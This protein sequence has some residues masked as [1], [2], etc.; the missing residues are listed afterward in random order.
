MSSRVAQPP[1]RV[2][3]AGRVPY[4]MLITATVMLL[5]LGSPGTSGAQAVRGTL[6]GKVGDAQGAAVP[7][8]TVTA[9][10]TQTNVARHVVTNQD[11]NYVFANLKDGLYRVEA[12]LA[13]FKKFAR[14][15]VEVKVNSTV[16]VDVTLEVGGLEETV[17]VRMETP[18][19]QT[20]RADTGRTIEGRQVTDLPLG[21]ARNFQGMW[22][23]VPGTVPLTRPHSQFFNPQDSQETKFNGQSRL[24][25]N[26]QV[27][28]LDNNH[29]TGLLTVLIPS[30]ESIDSVNVVTS[31]FDAE[32]GRAGGS[33]TTV[34]LKSG[35]NQFKGT[36][37][38][39]GNS[40][41]TQAR[42]AFASAGS[43]K[44]ETKFRQFGG[45][46][47][48]PI[49][50]DKLFFFADYQRVVDNLG[51]LRRVI[52][53]PAEWRSGN[54]STASTIIYDPATGNPDGTGRQ[55]FP[56]NIIPANRISPVARNILALLP[57][58]NIPGA[59]PGQ[60][61]FELPTSERE[62]TTNAFNVKLNYSPGASDQLSLRLSYQRPEIFVP[63]TFGDYGGAGA[64]FAGTGYQNTYSTALTWTRS[65]SSSLIMEWRAGYST[66]H[67]EALST[68]QGL[69]TSTEVGIPGANYDEFSSGLSRIVLQNGFTEP[70][71]GFAGSLPWDRGEDT[72]SVVGTLTK[73]AGNH[74][75]KVGTEVRHNEDFLL[76]IQDAGGVRGEF[77]FNAARTAI[78]SD[79]RATAGLANA[80]AAFLLDA[81]SLIRRDI[82]VIDR[83]GTK[84][85]SVFAF[86]QDKWQVSNKLTLDLGLRWE[87]YTPLVGIAE[88]GGLSN[89][90]PSNNTVR[91]AGY[92]SVPQDIG[93]KSTWTNFAPRVGASYRFNEK[94]V[95]RAGFGTT[96][97]PFPDNRYA[98]NFPVKQ[99]EVFTAPNSFAPAGRM[100]NGFGPPTFFP[101]PDSGI[102]DASIPQLRN[103]QL[104]YVQPDLKEAKLHSWNVAFQRELPWNLVGEVA[105]V[106]N[107][108]RGII[109]PDYNINAGQVLGADTAGQPFFQRFGRSA[110]VRS[111]LPTDTHYNALQ[112]KLDRRFRNGFM[113]TTS[114]TLGRAINYSQ[115]TDV[116]TP[117]ELERSKGRPDF[118]RLHAFAA[119]FIWELPLFREDKSTLGRIL[120]GWQIGGI[121]AI[122][123]GRPINFTAASATLRAPD[124]TQF[125]NQ[126]QRPE[127]FGDIGPGQL[128]FD[129]SV[130]SAPAQNTWGNMT[131]HSSIDGP[132]FWNVDL[133]LVKRFRFGSRVSAELRADAFNAFNHPNF[134]NPNGNFGQ[135]TFGQVTAT[136]NDRYRP[137]LVRFGARLTF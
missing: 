96:I 26:V 9:T 85:W 34:V 4:R 118:D 15:R 10:E 20:D 11:G 100:G 114:Y 61:N 43:L 69:N 52:I 82:K 58:P 103:A 51:Q 46:L 132:G 128:F 38:F 30:A 13:G 112:A 125:P 75:L 44:P 39:F 28:G 1:R 78:P 105:Y 108:G 94:T 74:T 6:L 106:G 127:V 53:P 77:Q 14:D 121:G 80:F 113:V 136:D 29:K 79:T 87:Y 21:Q 37:Y 116:L 90:D 19:L 8:V 40:E 31:N 102:V 22:A 104:F 45:T 70:M 7:G 27:D 131:R 88:Q 107:I 97:V 117:A 123:S 109:L 23:T 41:A 91:I 115:E 18:L 89:Y 33:V 55:P 42:N 3:Y 24:S 76:Q 64:D 72:Y 129:T 95:A 111:W 56:G 50:K 2:P 134:A 126:S 124:N 86:A 84:Q 68:G 71:L 60:V 135:A 12:E 73:L 122:Y 92:G 67:N 5:I 110:E 36:G 48:G 54:L 25:N 93:V 49:L 16:R 57:A 35:T 65:L 98:Y 83:P 130:F 101:I 81:P 66:Y 99:T 133:S 62:K 119:S 59:A 32:F 120:G 17:E 137:R 47:G 63:G